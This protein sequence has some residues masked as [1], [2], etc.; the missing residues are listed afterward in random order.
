MKGSENPTQVRSTV[1]VIKARCTY[2][3]SHKIL[4]HHGENRVEI[5]LVFRRKFRKM[6]VWGL[7]IT[8]SSL[9]T[10]LRINQ[11]YSARQNTLNKQSLPET[12]ACVQ[13]VSFLASRVWSSVQW[14]HLWSLS[15]SRPQA[16]T[17][18]G[19]QRDAHLVLCVCMSQT[20]T[21]TS[22]WNLSVKRVLY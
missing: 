7:S 9:I 1:R 18:L 21:E 16:Y 10:S 4:H 20:S 6:V 22:V 5:T 11:I 12:I 3:D 19:I 8:N 14:W 13:I 2:R 17:H 15:S